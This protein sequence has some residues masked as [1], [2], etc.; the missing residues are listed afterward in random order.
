MYVTVVYVKVKENHVDDFIRATQSNHQASI[1]EAGNLRF[2]ILRQRENGCEFMLYE[3]YRDEAAAAAHKD[4][5]HYRTWR[6][7]V[8]DWMAEPR[9]GVVYDGL[10]PK[11]QA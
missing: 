5:S 10:F 11:T 6:E 7:T 4:T 9:R 2:D 8:A 1:Q 3:A